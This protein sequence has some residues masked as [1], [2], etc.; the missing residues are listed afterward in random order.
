MDWFRGNAQAT[1]FSGGRNTSGFG[2]ARILEET[3]PR[4]RKWV[5]LD[6]EM[7]CGDWGPALAG[8]SGS[9]SAE[10]VYFLG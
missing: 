2:E 8:T 1:A 5:N 7:G 9:V 6:F 10:E 4:S 3:D